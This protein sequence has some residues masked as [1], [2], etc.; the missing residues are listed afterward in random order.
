MAGV[1]NDILKKRQIF[2]KLIISKLGGIYEISHILLILFIKKIT[3]KKY[4]NKY[5]YWH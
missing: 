4:K 3:L 1:V 2:L 5:L